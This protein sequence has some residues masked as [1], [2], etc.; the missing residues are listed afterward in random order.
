MAWSDITVT[1]VQ[2]TGTSITLSVHNPTASTESVRVRVT[3]NVTGGGTDTLTSDPLTLGSGETRTV[4]LDASDTILS[5]SDDPE[6]IP[7]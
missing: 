5:V 3:V 7:I 2:W 4:V 1:A 6:P